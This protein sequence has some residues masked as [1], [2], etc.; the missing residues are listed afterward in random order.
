MGQNYLDI[1]VFAGIA[2]VIIFKIVRVLGTR[3]DGEPTAEDFMR[4]FTKQGDAKD[5]D[6][7]VNEN[8][9]NADM[10]NAPQNGQMVD[11]EAKPVL[12]QKFVGFVEQLQQIQAI[13]QGFTPDK[14]IFGAEKA[15]EMI[16]ESY[17]KGEK[18]TINRFVVKD[19]AQF[20]NGMIDK[21]IQDGL[22]QEKKFLI[23]LNNS[24]VKNII[25]QENGTTFIEVE[26]ES[27]QIFAMYNAK[28]EC[29]QGNPN[30]ILQKTDIWVFT[31][32]LR[33]ANPIWFLSEIK[34]S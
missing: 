33:E 16:L 26:F 7:A 31:R 8:N 4:G 6:N 29:I 22:T 11:V 24:A 21:R 19:L 3:V 2:A 14:F 20:L 15:F 10:P 30:N 27:E 32:N 12:S 18:E 9:P 25:V 5:N 1:I 17:V 13:D 28:G 23:G 34:N